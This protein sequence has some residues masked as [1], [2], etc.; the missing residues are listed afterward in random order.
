M[1]RGSPSSFFPDRSGRR[2]VGDVGYVPDN[3]ACSLP[4]SEPVPQ[5]VPATSEDLVVSMR[6]LIGVCADYLATGPRIGV[7][8]TIEH[9]LRIVNAALAYCDGAPKESFGEDVEGFFLSGLLEELL[10]Q[11]SNLFVGTR[12]LHGEEMPVPISEEQWRECLSVLRAAIIRGDVEIGGESD[13]VRYKGAN[14]PGHMFV[15]ALSHEAGDTKT[16]RTSSEQLGAIKRWTRDYLGLVEDDVVVVNELNCRD[17]G[18][19]VVETAVV[20][21]AERCTMRWKFERPGFAVTKAMLEQTLA[22]PPKT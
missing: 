14:K 16:D 12:L 19:P 9:L 18:C 7:E 20:V 17:P 21:F 4:P 22:R 11:P 13:V 5:L 1:K 10:Q 6:R 15:P 3:A 8:P 2:V